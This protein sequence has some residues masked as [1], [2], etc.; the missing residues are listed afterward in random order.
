[1]TTTPHPRI[2]EVL[3]QLRDAQSD[4][5]ALLARVPATH[6]QTVVREG[7]WSAAHIVEHLAIV[8]DGTGRLVS[9]LIK[10]AEGTTETESAPILPTLARFHVEDSSV[11]RIE[12]PDMV[13]PR[14]GLSLDTAVQ[15]Q[16]VARERVIA[17]YAAASGRALAEVSAP[18]PILGPL[19]GYQ[20]G[21]FIAQHQRRHLVQLRAV[22]AALEV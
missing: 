14:A 7:T 1:M 20:W 22:L 9:K 6:S 13:A 3:T 18:H 10:Q 16:Q 15:T 21:I 19:N 8:E 17:A 12:A 2:E 11:R 4:M 5:Q